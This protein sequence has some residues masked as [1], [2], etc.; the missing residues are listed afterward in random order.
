MK[1]ADSTEYQSVFMTS[2]TYRFTRGPSRMGRPRTHGAEPCLVG[3]SNRI[4]HANS[5]D[6]RRHGDVHYAFH[7][8]L[9][10][11]RVKDVHGSRKVV[12]MD[13]SFVYGNVGQY[14]T[15]RRQWATLLE[16]LN[17]RCT[18]NYVN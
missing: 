6:A 12:G 16:R 13:N 14:T 11:R 3:A 2:G 17:R 8:V 15:I 1:H 4:D 10:H 9:T 5:D 18:F 7:S